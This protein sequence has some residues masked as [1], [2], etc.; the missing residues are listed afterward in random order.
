[1]SRRDALHH[2]LR[3][4]LE[5]DGWTITDDPLVL[6]LEDTLLKA[7]LG[8][9][10]ILTA[11]KENQKIALEIKGFDS[12]SVISD[13]EK[14]IG[15]LQLYQWALENQD[16]DRQL[17]LALDCQTYTKHFQKPLFQLVIQRNKIKL[18]IYDSIQEVILEWITP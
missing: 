11:E 9:E 6:I 8:S 2:T 17:F 12:P 13:L 3:R 7:D 1:M 16:P 10:K 5:K 15:Q 14:T 18:L 4:T